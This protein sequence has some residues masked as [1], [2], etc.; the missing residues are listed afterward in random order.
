MLNIDTL[1]EHELEAHT[2]PD[3]EDFN[4]QTSKPHPSAMLMARFMES[5]TTESE[6]TARVVRQSAS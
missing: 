1:R 6:R 4:L 2:N 3:F 5:C